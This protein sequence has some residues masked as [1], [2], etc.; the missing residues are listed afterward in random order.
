MPTIVTRGAASARGF[1]FA[2]V[3]LNLTTVTITSSTT[4]TAPTG[5]TNLVALIG[6]GGSSSSDYQGGISAASS[7]AGSSSSG[8]GSNSL[9]LSASAVYNTSNICA[10]AFN[11]GGYRSASYA[12]DRSFT[13][14]A[15]NT[16][17][18]SDSYPYGSSGLFPYYLVAGT[19]S[20]VGS[21]L[22]GSLSYGDSASYYAAGDAILPGSSGGNTTGFGYT[23][24][25]AAQVGS[26]PSATG[27]AATPVTYTNVAVTPG[28]GYSISVASGG[29]VIIQYLA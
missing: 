3:D 1:G 11:A 2:G 28:V 7:D 27:Q 8:S 13:F 5:V 16:F 22:S 15:N 24:S 19:W 9:P 20:L 6:Q 25:G 14:Y 12:V 18:W 23:F 4:W 26:Y 29:S 10:S 17:S 21:P